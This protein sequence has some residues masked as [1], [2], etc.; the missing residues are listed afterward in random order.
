[1]LSRTLGKLGLSGCSTGCAWQQMMTISGLYDLLDFR[2]LN[3]THGQMPRTSIRQQCLACNTNDIKHEN[4]VPGPQGQK[5]PR[6]WRSKTKK[7]LVTGLLR[8]EQLSQYHKQ[9]CKGCQ[10]SC[11]GW[12]VADYVG[13]VETGLAPTP[14]PLPTSKMHEP[15]LAPFWRM[16]WLTA[17][18]GRPPAESGNPF[19][20]Q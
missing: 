15:Q 5:A 10:R 14:L 2:K 13:V 17:T 11:K 20:L 19:P 6:S 18:V 12:V 16:A 9:A 8:P 4:H 3:G 7:P 1:M